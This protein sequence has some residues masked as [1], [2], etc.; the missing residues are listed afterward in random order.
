MAVNEAIMIKTYQ[1]LLFMLPLLTKLPRDQKFLVADRY[2][3]KVLDLLDLY[4]RAYYS[5]KEQKPS[6]SRDANIGLEQLRYL[7]RLLHVKR[8]CS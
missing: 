5:S 2:E 8:N 7:T 3:M 1:F 4:V 6:M